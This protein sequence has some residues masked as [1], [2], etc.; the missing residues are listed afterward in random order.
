MNVKFLAIAALACFH[1]EASNSDASVI[2]TTLYPDGEYDNGTA[3]ALHGSAYQYG[4]T[5][6][7][8]R[9]FPTSGGFLSSIDFG[10]HY[11]ST[12]SPSDVVDVRVTPNFS[13]PVNGNVP[14]AT[15]LA[16]G[17][18]TMTSSFGSFGLVSFTPSTTVLL[19][20]GTSYWVV[21]SPHFDTTYGNWNVSS[22]GIEGGFAE[23][24]NGTT[25]SQNPSTLLDAFRV[26]ATPVPEPGAILPAAGLL[27]AL[28]VRHGRQKPPT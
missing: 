14:S 7:A 6:L 13:D 3:R 8:N 25:W 16:S 15:T 20:A 11:S 18:V 27:G 4:Y 17:S 28:A 23:T 9:F 10:L 24:F 12:S 19:S 22:R 1:F 5:A 2:F 21:L 26:N